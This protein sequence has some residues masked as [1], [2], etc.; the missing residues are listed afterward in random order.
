MPANLPENQFSPGN[1]ESP[2]L[3][4]GVGTPGPAGP[5]GPSGPTGPFGPTGPAGASTTG[6]TG[7]TG[8]AGPAGPAGPLG[9]TGPGG[10]PTGPAGPAGPS[11]PAG[12]TGPAG[13]TGPSASIAAAYFNGSVNNI[14]SAAPIRELTAARVSSGSGRFRASVNIDYSGTPGNIVTWEVETQ[15]G[16]GAV[17][18][19]NAGAVGVGCFVSTSPTL[20]IG[21][22]GGGGSPAIPRNGTPQ[23]ATAQ[24]S[25]S[26]AWSGEIDNAGARFPLGQNVFLSLLGGAAAAL[27]GMNASI[28]LEEIP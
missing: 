18:T 3:T 24:S 23:L 5:A 2:A 25:S 7:P 22:T 21:I 28:W 9:P 14:T 26:W 10:G 15:T 6:P 11:G 17:T 8:P 20:G 13:P 27:S 1:C 16:S 12:A 19:T 4:G